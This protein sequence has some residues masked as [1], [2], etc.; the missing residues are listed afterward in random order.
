MEACSSSAE[1]AV[2]SCE[3]THGHAST[4]RVSTRVRGDFCSSDTPQLFLGLLAEAPV[5]ML[6]F[7]IWTHVHQGMDKDVSNSFPVGSQ[8]AI[9]SERQ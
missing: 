8:T 6:T 5:V 4:T 7:A 2:P 1:K 9:T 3:H